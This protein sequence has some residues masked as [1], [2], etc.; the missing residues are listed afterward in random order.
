MRSDTPLILGF[1]TTAAQCAA[2]LLGGDRILGAARQ[3]MSRGQ[4]ERLMVMLE[5]VL[6]SADAD[7]GD[8]DALA[9]CTGPGNFTGVRISVAAARG[10]ALALE[11]PAIGISALEASAFGLPGPVLVTLQ[12]RR[13]DLLAQ[14]FCDGHPLGP[15]GRTTIEALDPQPRETV[16]IGYHAA[17]IADRLDLV[18]GSE[19]TLVNPA[20]LARAAR[21]RLGAEQ[22]PPLPLYLHAADAM[23]STDMAPRLLDDA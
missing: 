23:S 15:P 2:V 9:V 14:A 12:D 1:D 16:C 22:P 13:G 21:A 10:L 6:S 5:E 18:V 3:E 19:N 7:W 8:L 20:A 17:L 4:A 11:I